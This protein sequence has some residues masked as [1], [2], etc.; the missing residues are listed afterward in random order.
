MDSTRKDTEKP[1]NNNS[2]AQNLPFLNNGK[3]IEYLMKI[4]KIK[5]RDQNTDSARKDAEKPHNNRSNAQNMSLLGNG[6][7]TEVQMNTHKVKD[8]EQYMGQRNFVR[9]YDNVPPRMNDFGS[10]APQFMQGLLPNV[11]AI[12]G[13][14][15]FLP[16]VP[17]YHGNG[18]QVSN[19][20][21]LRN[22][23]KLSY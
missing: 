21:M 18:M 13:A 19:I 1:Q 3:H 11:P 2:N 12:N 4:P 5:D 6:K 8:R 20:T 14:R 10:I 7:H 22:K 15:P 23:Y 9:K 17:F 16:N